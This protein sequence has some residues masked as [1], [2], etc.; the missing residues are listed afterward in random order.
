M[1]VPKPFDTHRSTGTV[2]HGGTAVVVL[3]SEQDRPHAGPAPPGVA[4]R[5]RPGVVVSGVPP[6]PDHR[7]E[8]RR[9]PQHPAAGPPSRPATRI[10]FGV[11]SIVPVEVAAQKLVERQRNLHLGLHVPGAGLEE[12]DTMRGVFGEPRRQHA[13]G[14]PAAHDEMVDHARMMTNSPTRRHPADRR[15]SVHGRWRLYPSCDA[16]VVH[17]H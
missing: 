11:G 10:V 2:V 3:H 8:G 14:R 6:H 15:M 16:A 5:S 12:Q 9:P 13:P 7:I 4:G 17:T 1:G